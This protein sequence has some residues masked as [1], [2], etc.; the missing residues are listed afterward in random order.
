MSKFIELM[1]R[2][3]CN[4]ISKLAVFIFESLKLLLNHSMKYY[5]YMFCCEQQQHVQNK[6]VIKL[7]F[8]F[9]FNAYCFYSQPF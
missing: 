8:Q 5:C 3:R 7:C 4:I 9:N 1:T 6:T 2:D